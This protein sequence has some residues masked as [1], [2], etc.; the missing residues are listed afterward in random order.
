MDEWKSGKDMSEYVENGFVL[1]SKAFE[2]IIKA[3]VQKLENMKNTL[4]YINN[5]NKKEE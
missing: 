3:E 1:F 4:N 2:L 5:Q